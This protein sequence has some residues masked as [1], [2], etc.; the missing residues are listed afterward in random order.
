MKVSLKPLLAIPL[1]SILLYGA[2][3][4]INT[5]LA[6]SGSASVTTASGT[7]ANFNF[8]GTSSS[9]ELGSGLV[10]GAGTLVLTSGVVYT[11]TLN[12]TITF[13]STQ[14]ITGTST[15]SSTSLNGITPANIGFGAV[16]N[17][18]TGGT[19]QFASASGTTNTATGTIIAPSLGVLAQAFSL[20]FGG[21]IAINAPNSGTVNSSGLRFVPITPCRVVDTRNPAGA[22]G[23][24]SLQAQVSRDFYLWS[25][26][27]GISTS[28]AAYSLNV[29]VVPKGPLSY[30]TIW[31]S[32][33]PQPFVST[34]N[35]AD[36]RT[37]ANAAIVPA[38]N[39]GGVSVYATNDAD[40]ILDVNG[41]FEPNV[42]TDLVFYP[43][44]PCRIADTRNPTAPLGGPALIAGQGRTFPVLNSSCGIPNTVKAYALNMTVVPATALSYLTTWPTGFPQP[45]V[46]T[47]NSP[48]GAVLANAAIVPAG[49]NGS[50][51]VY[52]TDQSHLIIDIN[53]YFAPPASGGLLFYPVTPCRM[54]DTRIQSGSLFGA[55]SLQS[56]QA[57]AF[58]LLSTSCAPSTSAQAYS[59]NVTAV[60]QGPLS[61][62]T[63]W[64]SGLMQPLVSTLNAGDGSVTA[65]AAIVPNQGG[66]IN[67]FA[68]NTADVLFDL[69]GYFAP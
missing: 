10:S 9:A 39:S 26:G 19:G 47:L 23:G 35:S 61:Y 34:L 14:T 68:T 21:P 33:Q 41:Y 12:Y 59:M 48:T 55:P 43:L 49:S 15:G 44:T 64:Q 66:S 53:G 13:P 4:T 58:P 20:S 54:V 18:I 52:V 57:R 36:G 11:Y 60:P 1:S 31:P 28:A 6:I 67:A 29:T 37:K 30:L 50:I 46:S 38:G 7:G 27:C 3:T 45:L 24:P 16:T 65:N 51:D 32:G 69:N 42:A 63:L 40:V 8:T 2:G 5:N 22:F 56:G 17:T 62:L 25:A